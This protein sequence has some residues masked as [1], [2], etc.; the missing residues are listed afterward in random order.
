MKKTILIAFVTLSLFSCNT[1]KK[2]IET[3]KSEGLKT[4]SE[5]TITRPGDTITIDIPNVRYKDTI[6]ERI[7]YI[8][9]SVARVTYD[10]NGNQR[11]ECLQAEMKEEF[12][13]LREEFKNDKKTESESETN[14]E[15][16]KFIYALA[17]LGGV[18]VIA[19]IVAL[20]AFAKIK[21]SIPNIVI[22]S[23]KELNK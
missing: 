15:P 22:D 20:V 18:I 2:T 14:F 19:L 9:K 11:F 5:H 13:L 12:R 16:Q 8:N 6:I 3:D 23:L 7:D 10:D 1:A 21:Q 17:I 4:I